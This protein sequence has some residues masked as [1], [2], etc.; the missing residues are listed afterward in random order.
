MRT[1]ATLRLFLIEW[2]PQEICA[3]LA[4]AKI[5]NQTTRGWAV[6]RAGKGVGA[7]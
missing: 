2:L 3:R 5:K 6:E 4:M 7:M 1:G